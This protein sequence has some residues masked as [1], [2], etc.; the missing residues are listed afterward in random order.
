MGL[1]LGGLYTGAYTWPDIC[2]KVKVKR[3]HDIQYL[4]GKR[5]SQ[6]VGGI[7]LPCVYPLNGPKLHK[8]FVREALKDC[9]T[10]KRDYSPFFLKKEYLFL[11]T[12]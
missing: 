3:S 6:V 11:N 4:L 2:V 12:L 9:S 7:E 1:Y 10:Y 5:R 8:R